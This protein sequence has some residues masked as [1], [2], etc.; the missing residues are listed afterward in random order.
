LKLVRLV[1][2]F[3]I[4]PFHC[5]LA[6]AGGRHKAQIE[7]TRFSAED[8]RVEKPVEVPADVL[9]LLKQDQMVRNVLEDQSRPAHDLPVSWFSAS[10]I[11]L[12]PTEETD[13]VVV[14]EPPL[15]GA[16][17][18]TFWVFRSTA[19]GYALVLTAPAHDLIVKGTRSF[20]VRDIE[21]LA[22]TA[23]QVHTVLFRFDGQQYKIYREKW[24][25]IR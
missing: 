16:N 19:Q 3:V 24:E 7:Q 23:M 8:E 21:M 20:G 6:N 1:A 9:D 12:G 15:S 17:T 25:P 18:V 4:I 10:A 2:L 11:H 5:T 22:T 14:G 13:L